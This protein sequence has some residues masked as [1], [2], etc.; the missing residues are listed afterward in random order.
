MRAILFQF[1]SGE[2][3]RSDPPW[4]LLGY[5]FGLTLESL[6]IS[7]ICKKKYFWAN[8]IMIK[9]FLADFICAM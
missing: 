1:P 2:G 9:L 5:D 7:W 4:E 6:D 8:L 3:V